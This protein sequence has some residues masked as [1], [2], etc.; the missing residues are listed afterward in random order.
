MKKYRV[1]PLL[2]ATI[3]LLSL[4]GCQKTEPVTTEDVVFEDVVADE[5]VP[6]DAAPAESLLVKKNSNA[7]IDYSHTTDGYVTVCW[8]GDATET[9]KVRIGCPGSRMYLYNLKTD[10]SYETLPLTEGDGNY[11][12]Q[13]LR[14][15]EGTKY[16]SVLK[17]VITAK[18][19]EF[20]PFLRSNQYVKY[21]DDSNA[22]KLAAELC[23][24]ATDDIQKTEA[25]YNFVV[26]NL[27]YDYEKAATVKSGY[28]PKIDEVLEAKKGICSDYA[29]LMVAM[30][31]SQ[32]VPAKLIFGWAGDEYHAWVEVYSKSEGS[33]NDS[34]HFDA[35]GWKRMD[36]TFAST[37]NSCDAVMNYIADDANYTVNFV[38]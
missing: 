28:I 4:F 18:I 12:V 23:A 29:V 20:S 8:T 14:Q 19:D 22:I 15:K 26:K 1:I 2:L 38:R 32:G 34:I 21:S 37:G 11:T 16:V 30:L 33:V 5:P 35:N 17:Q 24:N 3:M 9:V 31:R 7:V 25:I 13:V 10:G 27:T 36:P 6:M